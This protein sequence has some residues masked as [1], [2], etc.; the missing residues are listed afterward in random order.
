MSWVKR[1]VATTPVGLT[2]PKWQVLLTTTTEPFGGNYILACESSKPVFLNRLNPFW[3]DVF[4]AWQNL[5]KL[6][7]D[8]DNDDAVNFLQEPL[9]HNDKIR[10]DNKPFFYRDWY[11]AGA[12]FVNDLVDESGRFY[13]YERFIDCFGIDTHFLAYR[14]VIDA[15]PTAWKRVIRQREMKVANLNVAPIEALFRIG[16]ATKYFYNLGIKSIATTPIK[17]IEKWRTILG[18][19]EDDW[20]WSLS[21]TQALKCTNETKSRFFQLKILHRFLPTNS[22]LFRYRLKETKSCSFC[23]VYTEKLEHLFWECALV[24]SIWLQLGEWLDGQGLHCELSA[25][26]VLLGDVTM[27]EPIPHI[28]LIT[29]E[30]IYFTKLQDRPLSFSALKAYIRHKCMVEKQY[31][32]FHR[33][34]AKWGH[35]LEDLAVALS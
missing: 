28:L 29:K 27:Q 6:C 24:K 2:P 15:I 5:S 21:F 8:E 18:L 19:E 25:K 3:Q 13:S 11:E 22:L 7:I 10:I 32:P 33:F 20:D 17:S 26:S 35:I 9:F 30:Y 4:C 16:N 1:L 14:S 23:E 31:K 34:V 12:S